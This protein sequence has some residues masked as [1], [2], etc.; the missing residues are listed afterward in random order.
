MFQE[1]ENELS[2]NKINVIKEMKVNGENSSIKAKNMSGNKEKEEN[3][4]NTNSILTNQTNDTEENEKKK[5]NLI[6][7][8]KKDESLN[9]H[10]NKDNIININ[11][12]LNQIIVK[13]NGE[14]QNEI[15]DNN[16]VKEN[17]NKFN[18]TEDYK[19]E[20]ENNNKSQQN[21]KFLKNEEIIYNQNEIEIN[22][23]SSEKEEKALKEKLEEDKK[24]K[25]GEKNKL[26]EKKGKKEEIMKEDPEG[27]NKEKFN[28]NEEKKKTERQT[29]IEKEIEEKIKSEKENPKIFVKE[30]IEEEELD[31]EQLEIEKKNKEINE[32]KKIENKEEIQ[33]EKNQEKEIKK[34]GNKEKENKGEIQE[35]IQENKKK[36]I[37]KEK[38]EQEEIK[39]KENKGK[40][41]EKKEEI[42]EN[43]NKEENKENKINSNINKNMNQI[44]NQQINENEA[45][46]NN[47][48]ILNEINI[49]NENLFKEKEKKNLEEEEDDEDDF[50]DDEELQKLIEQIN[51]K[52]QLFEKQK[53][54]EELKEKMRLEEE[55]RKLEEKKR[56][57]EEEKKKLEAKKKKLEEKRASKKAKMKE[58]LERQEKEILDFIE[59]KKKK[60]EQQKKERELEEKLRKEEEEKKK[61]LEKK[62]KEEEEI[63]EKQ[64]KEKERLDKL[65]E[66]KIERKK[67]QVE[68][69]LEKLNK[70]NQR[71]LEEEKKEK[72]RQEK[73]R[74]EKERIEKE[75]QEKERQEKERHEKELKDKERKRQESLERKRNELRKKQKEKEEK[76]RKLKEEEERKKIEEDKKKEEEKK[77]KKE[78][79][80]AENYPDGISNIKEKDDKTKIKLKFIHMEVEFKTE[81]KKI[82]VYDIYGP[83]KQ[84]YEVLL[85][86]NKY[87]SVFPF[88]KNNQSSN[89]IFGLRDKVENKIIDDN[90]ISGKYLKFNKEEKSWELT[91]LKNKNTEMIFNIYNVPKEINKKDYLKFLNKLNLKLYTFSINCVRESTSSLKYSEILDLIMEIGINSLSKLLIKIII[92]RKIDIYHICHYLE[93]NKNL[94]FKNNFEKLA[95]EII[96]IFKSINIE[97]EEKE[98]NIDKNLEENNCGKRTSLLCLDNNIPINLYPDNYQQD[99]IEK[100]IKNLKESTLEENIEIKRKEISEKL[101]D[102]NKTQK[103]NKAKEII[104]ILTDTTIKKIIKLEF[105]ILSNIPMIIQG[106]TSAGKSFLSSVTSKINKRECLSAAL[107]E[108]TTIEDLLGRDIINNDSSIKFIPGIL[109]LAYKDGKT[110]ILD[111][112][113]LAQPEILSCILGSMTKNELIICNQ[114]FRKME[115]Y[116]VILTMNGEVKGFNEKQ[117][118]ILTSNIVSKFIP[119]SFEE[120]DKEECEEIFKSLLKK[121]ENSKEYLANIKVFIEIHQKMIEEMKI[122]EEMKKNSKSIDPIVTLRNLKYC[123]YLSKNLIHPRLAAE[124]SYT[125]RFPENERKEFENILNKFGACPI[126]N[127]LSEEIENYLQNNFLYYNNTYKKVIY[128]STMALKEGLHPLLVGEKGCGLTTLAKVV[129]SIVSKEYEFLFCS[130]E[131][132]VEDLLGC[133]QPRIKS[134]DKIQDLSSYIKWCDGPVPKAGKRGVPLILDNINY[135]KPQVI[136]CLN[137]ILE[138]NTK[139]NNVEYNILEKE[140]EG[141]IK[142]KK[143]FSILATM[144]IDKDNNKSISKALM[145]RFVPIYVDNDMDINKENLNIIIE[146]IGKKLDSQIK[147][148]N[149]YIENI[150]EKPENIEQELEESFSYSESSDQENEIIIDEEKEGEEEEQKENNN[151]EEEKNEIKSQIPEWYNIK[152]ISEETIIEIQKYFQNN[153]IKKM[154]FKILMKTITKLALVYE[155]IKRF[156]FTMEDCN[157]F[158]ELKFNGKNEIYLNLQNNILSD[159]KEKKNKFFFNEF[160]SDSWKMIMSLIS[161]NISNTC[162]FLQGSPGSGKS[163]AARH[164][165][166]YRIFNNRNPIL[167]VNCNRDLKFDYLVGN[168]NFKDS[169]FNFIDGPLITAIKKG[170][171]ILLDEFNL[172]PESVLTNLLPLFKANINEEIYLKGFPEPIKI[173]PGFLLIA[174]G[175][176][177]KEKGRKII[178]NMIM[179]EILTL[180]ISSINLKSNTTL[181]KNILENEYREIYQEDNSFELDKISSEQIK[182][183]VE[184]LKEDI[185]FNLSLRQIKCLLE[186]ITRF[187]IEENYNVGGFNKIPVIYVIISYIIPQLKIGKKK[188]KEF[189]EKL[190]KTMKY[191]K[192]DELMQFIGSKVELE[193]TIIKINDK[194]EEKRFIKKGNIY[195]VT[196][197]NENIFPQVALQTFFWIRMSCSLKNESPSAE[198]ILLAGTTSYKEYLLN[199]WLSLKVQKDKTIDTLYLTKNTETDNLIG[200]S[201]LDDESKIE[202]QIN[203]LIDNAIFYFY[204]DAK[205]ID[206]KDYNKKF[207]LIKKNKNDSLCLRY[208]YENILKLKSLKKS[209]N[210]N[211]TQIGLKTVTS[212][213]LG[214]IPKAFIF[215]KKLILKG[216]ENP[217]S[218]V[219][220]RLNPLLENPRHLI[221]TEDN[222]KIYND[223]K[224]FKKIY[225]ENIKSVPLN[226]SFRMFFTSREVFH[227]K[228]SKALLSRLT[229][230]NCPNYD[231]ENYLT[232]KLE[233]EINYKIICKSILEETHLVDEIIEFSKI[234][235]TIEKI[236]FLRFIRWC[237]STKNI[238]KRLEKIE[239]QTLLHNQDDSLNYKYIIGISCLRS[240]IDRFESKNRKKIIKEHFKDYLPEKLFNLLTTE[241]NNKLEV[242]PLELIEKNGK[243]YISSIYSGI[244]LEFPENENP[245]IDS[246]K[247]INWTQ[248]SVDIVDAIIV[249]LISNTILILEG[250]PG[251]GKTAISKAVFNYLNIDNE[252]L[253]RINFS[254]SN[255]L[256][257]VFARTIPKIEGEKV[258]TVRKEQGLLSI[259]RKSQNS[260]QFYLQGLIL[261]E[262]NLASDILLEYLYSYMN[263]IL[264]H[265]DYISPDGIKYQNIGN[266]GV[267]ATMNGAKLSN[268]RTNLSN[269]FM[270]RCHLLKLSDYSINE[271]ELLAE[272]ILTNLP[273]KEAFFKVIEY[274]KISSRIASKYSDFEGNTFREILKLRQFIDKCPDIPID[275][276]LELILS[277]NI[278]PS[279]MENF[280]AETGFNIISNSLNDLKLKIENKCL[281]FDNFVKYKL[282]NPKNYEIKTQFTISQ[283]EALMKIMIGLLAERPILLTGDIGTGKTFIV[284]QLANLIGANL[285]VIQFNSETTSLDILGRLELTIDKNKINNLK[286][287]I[288]KFIEDLIKIKYKKITEIIIENELLNISKIQ[289][290]LENEKEDF[291]NYDLD[292]QNEYEEIRTQLINLSGIKK[293][294]FNFNLSALIKAMIQGDWILLDDINFAPHEI[295][296]L[297]PLLEEEPTLKIYE[298][299]PVLFF[300]K[301][302]SKIINKE[303]DFEIHPNFKLIM[304]T[305]KDHN[306]SAA[307]KSRCLCVQIKPFKEPKDY[308]ELIANN[309]IYCDIADNNIIDI[310][311]KIGY[312]FYKL[313]E[314][315]E[316]TNYI[317]K[318]YILSSVNLV[319]L[320]KLIICNQP[321]NDKKLAH[322]IEYC[323][324]SAFK[325]MNKKKE[326]IEFFRKE[327][328]KDINIEITPIRNIKRSHEYYLKKCEINIFSYYFIK[329]KEIEN[330]LEKMNEKINKRFIDYRSE[331]K[332]NIIN[333]NINEKEIIKDIPREQL[334]SKLESFT[335]PEIKEYIND[336]DELII[337]INDFLEEDDKLYQKLYFLNYLRM[338]LSNLSE[339]NEEKLFGIKINKM[340]CNK[341]FFLKYNIKEDVSITY[342]RI[343]I[344]FKNMIKYFDDIIP[345]K[346]STNEL[347]F[348]ILSIYYKSFKK[349]YKEIKENQLFEYFIFFMLS[350]IHLRRIVKKYSV[351][352]KNSVG[353]DLFNILKNYNDEI[354]VNIHERKIDIEKY[355]LS[356][357]L[358]RNIN[359]KEKEEIEEILGIK[360]K[361]EYKNYISKDIIKSNIIYYYPKKFYEEKHLLKIFFFYNI[362]IKKYIDDNELKKIIPDE[363]YDYN[364]VIDFLFKENKYYDNVDER[365]IW[366]NKYNFINII[367]IG[368]KLLEA[369]RKV[370][371]ESIKLNNGID[372]FKNKNIEINEEN[373]N[374]VI[375]KIDIIKK[376][377][378][379]DKLWSSIQKK[380]E[381][382]EEKKKQLIFAKEKNVLKRKLDILKAKYKNILMEENYLFLKED[383]EEIMNKIKENNSKNDIEKDLKILENKFIL[384]KESQEKE[385]NQRE[386]YPK[387]NLNKKITIYSKILYTYS[388]LCSIIEEFNN[389][390]ITADFIR[391][392][393]K[394]QKLIK[395]SQTNIDV[396]SAYKEQIFSSCENDSFVSQEMIEIFKHMAKSYLISEIIK[397]SLENKFD[398]YIIH[399]MQI[400]EKIL[401]DIAVIFTEDEYIYLPKLNSKDII[402]CFRYGEDNYKPGILNP[403]KKI[404]LFFDENENLSRNEILN[405]IRENFTKIIKRKEDL[406][407]INEYLEKIDTFYNNI[408][409]IQYNIDIS[410]L[411]KPLENLKDEAINY[412]NRII[413][414]NKYKNSNNFDGK[415]FDGEKI[416]VK[417]IYALYEGNKKIPTLFNILNDVISNIQNSNKN[418]HYGYRIMEFYGFDLFSDNQSKTMAIIIFSI[419]SI[420]NKEFKDYINEDMISILQSV[421]QE[422]IELVISIE[423]PKFED[424]QA[425]NIFKILFYSFLKKFKTKYGELKSIF[426]ENKNKFLDIVNKIKTQVINKIN[427]EISEYNTKYSIYEENKKKLE[428]DIEDKRH[429]FYKEKS[430]ILNGIKY[431]FVN[432]DK[433]FEKTDEYKN[434]SKKI[435]FNES[436]KP[437]IDHNWE[438]NKENFEKL[439]KKLISIKNKENLYSIQN[440]INNNRIDGTNKYI[441]K[442]NFKYY[443]G[444]LNKLNQNIDNLK[445]INKYDYFLKKEIPVDIKIYEIQKL[446]L[447]MINKIILQL[448]NYQY[449]YSLFEIKKIHIGNYAYKNN[450]ISNN[451]NT[452]QNSNFIFIKGNNNPVFLNK[453]MKINLGLYIIGCDLKNIGS[454]S[455]QNN[456]PNSLKYSIKQDPNNSIIIFIDSK[457][458]LNPYQDLK[459]NFKLNIKDIIPGFYSSECE[460]I[461]SDENKEFDKCM[462]NVFINVIP[463]IIKFSIPNIE[464]SLIN[465]NISISNYIEDLRI[466]H[467]FP[468][469]YFPESLGIELINRNYN[470]LKVIKDNMKNKGQLIVKSNFD[471][472]KKEINFELSLFLKSFPLLKFQINY[473]NPVLFGIRIFDAKNFNLQSIKIMKDMEK[474]FYLFN[475]SNKNIK[476]NLSYNQNLIKITSSKKELIPKEFVK[477]RVKNI[478]L[479]NVTILNI[480]DKSIKI[481]SIKYPKITFYK[482]MIACNFD[483]FEEVDKNILEGFKLYSINNNF[484]V[485]KE[486][487]HSKD[488]YL[489][490]IFSGYLIFKKEIITK[491]IGKYNFEN[492]GRRKVYGYSNE[493]SNITLFKCNDKKLK[494][495]LSFKIGKDNYYCSIFS[496]NKR[497]QFLKNL[498]NN[499]A[500][501]ISNNLQELNLG[502]SNI[503]SQQ[504]NIS[505]ENSV[506]NLNI[507]NEVVSVENIIIFLLKYSLKFK[508]IDNFKKYLQESFDKLYPKAYRDIKQFFIP[509]IENENVKIILDK[510][511]YILSFT[512]LL[513]SPGELLEYEYLE[514]EPLYIKKEIKIEDNQNLNKLQKE[515]DY[516]FSNIEK[517]ILLNKDLIYYNRKIMVHEENDVFSKYEKQIKENDIKV[518]ENIEEESTEFINSCHEKIIQL[519]EYINKNNINISNLLPFLDDSKK[520]LMKIPFILSKKGKEEQLNTSING[521]QMIYYYLDKLKETDIMKTQ[522]EKIILEYLNEFKYFLSKFNIFSVKDQNLSKN[523]NLEY[524][525]LCELPSDTKYDEVKFYNDNDEKNTKK[526]DFNENKYLMGRIQMEQYNSEILIKDKYENKK[527][528]SF[529]KKEDKVKTLNIINEISE[530]ERKNLSIEGVLDE[531]KMNNDE[532]GENKQKKALKKD[533]TDFKEELFE[534]RDIRKLFGDLKNISATKFLKDIMKIVSTEN[535]KYSII[536][537]IEKIENIKKDKFENLNNFYDSKFD[538]SYSNSSSVLQNIISNL[539]RKKV[540][541]FNEKEILPKTLN[542]TYLEILLDISAT[543]S[544]DQR[545][546]SLLV[547]TGLSLSFSKYGVKIRIGVFA[548]RDNVWVLSDDFSYENL[549]LQL[550]RLRDALSLRKRILSF[551]ADALKKL[552][553]SFYEQYNKKY[554]QILISN[555]ISSQIVDKNLNW[556]ELGQRIIVFGLKSNFEEAFKNEN[557]DIYE[558]ILKVPTSD[559]AQIVQEFFEPYEIISQSEK[560]IDSYSNL[561]NAIIDS[562]LDNNEELNENNVRP[563]LINDTHYPKRKKNDIEILKIFIDNNLKEQ[564]YFAQ[565]IPFL[566]LK[567]SK[568]STKKINKNLKIPSLSE[569]EKLSSKDNYNKNYSMEEIISFIV[570]LL[571]PLFRQI[572]PSN[573]ASGKIPSTSGGSL[574]IQGIKKW[575]CSGF[576]YTYIF[577]KQGGKNKKK[578]NLSYVIDLSRS[579]LLLCNY[580][581]CIVTIVLLLIAP[582]TVEDNE[583]IFIDVL[584]NT[585]YGVKIVDFNSKCTIFQNISKI[586][587]IINIINEE[588]NYSCCPGSC[589]Y[590]SYQLLSERREEKKIFLIT[591]GFVTD[592]NEI[593]LVLN[594]IENCEN[595]GIDLVTIG[596][597]TF[598]Y[599]I[600]DVYPN[601][602]YSP[603]IRNIQDALFSCFFYSKETSIN[604]FDSNLILAEF[605]EKI[606]KELT[607]I[608][609]EKPKDKKLEDSISNDP[610]QFNLI[611]NENSNLN[612]IGMDGITKKVLNP[613]DEPYFDVFSDFKI[614]IV[615]LYLGDDKHDKNITTEV[616]EQNAG[617]SLK[618]KGFKY[619]LVYSYG[620]AINKLSVVENNNCPYSELWIFCSKGDGSLPVKA[621]DKDNNKITIFLEMV[622]DFNK[623]G[624]ALFLFCDN[625]PFVLEANL[626]LKE[627][628]KFEEG[629]INFEMKGNYN[630]EVEQNRFIYEKDSE[631]INGN[632]FFQPD[633]FLK[634][635]GKA[636]ERFSLRIGLNKFSEGIT[637]SF[638]ETSNNSEDYSPFTP[639]AYLTDP[640]N[641]RPFI[642]YY[643]PKVETGRG[644]IVVHGGF[645]S[646]FY[647]FQQDGTGRLVI[648]IACW[649]I[650]KEEININIANGIEKVIPSIPIPQN[651]NIAFDK[652]IKIKGVGKMFS[653]LILDVSGSMRKFYSSLFGLANQIIKN[654]MKNDENEGIIILFGTYAKAIVNGKYRLLDLIDINKAN[655]G[656]GT[657]F[658]IAF[659]EAEKYI[660]NRNNFPKKRILFLTDGISSSSQL[661]PICNKMTQENFQINIVGFNNNP[662]NYNSSSTTFEHLRKFASPNCFFTS[663]NFKEIEEICINIFAAE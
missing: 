362:F 226:E 348:S 573:I 337:I 532:D 461:L 115:G 612:S 451:I 316:Q 76:E 541:I 445:I 526:N 440:I 65:E 262:I 602:C 261:D 312:G 153:N 157:D 560:I 28:L 64:R 91:I 12:N 335:L 343:L 572:M 636:N 95:P 284:E 108:N 332:E 321:I 351:L 563:I 353:Y 142:M 118:N 559:Q 495:A 431:T 508:I 145:N 4:E 475:M 66:E 110:L 161:S 80:H 439:A 562:L 386:N 621:V 570:T 483:C 299:D 63:K 14:N 430:G 119:I 498:Q 326:F 90:D 308:S 434:W 617:K 124:I 35:K 132:S 230:I 70:E 564:K 538:I 515:Y 242:C 59:N 196:N 141:P 258:S 631:K 529:K 629:K 456:Y 589:V 616:F 114:T 582:S 267:I 205:N 301:D 276:L 546:A 632:G 550:S 489:Y 648:S 363:L 418:Y 493:N 104:C 191:N 533:L 290:F 497:N 201:S 296:G 310:A 183:I 16:N 173:T 207:K 513:L 544:E 218:S 397:N 231:N 514:E 61:I 333:K 158:I 561:V 237:Q 535:Q 586:Q 605:D 147:E 234:I 311:K 470:N 597:G 73:E 25:E 220:E 442:N 282:I 387:D 402:Y 18:I 369:I 396:L 254:P 270:N 92:D 385:E 251:R 264:H 67:K 200:I 646:A 136:E 277:R 507:S 149:N 516:Y 449:Y 389:I 437:H 300:T 534:I 21:A 524:I 522:F 195:L 444:F 410:W 614:L 20:K 42:Q 425:V 68:D 478:N 479:E 165:G 482:P 215:G 490:N 263:S 239:F 323:F 547:C 287:S 275:Y 436:E 44:I 488:R 302:R 394:F 531:S 517:N 48:K 163:C 96:Y 340:E 167:S 350:K 315:E 558:N 658:Y 2:L 318:N 628:I 651:N 520:I 638:A 579:S 13:E 178:S 11:N 652:W 294:H 180:E 235:E 542:N 528:L 32:R 411:I 60:E 417:A 377:L 501:I 71:L 232:L 125:A 280:K 408:D 447:G 58:E 567:L 313:K 455:I 650:R 193:P 426:E 197:M 105:G 438:I 186:R 330:I 370:E 580:S 328:Q 77:L 174:T 268:S 309:L 510:F 159:S 622:A 57:E 596:V 390:K 412:P 194:E 448:D 286:K 424:T 213:N 553:N 6:H 388:K 423:Y 643:D 137:P 221:I 625:Y 381:I 240:I 295:E 406:E 228:L 583:E 480:N 331:L 98:D 574:S 285:K 366:K 272:K 87:Y 100:T 443:S 233:P 15:L 139:Y 452:K 305:S 1:K 39:E 22:K 585:V 578:Y 511:S 379:D 54:E 594:L 307:I 657:N 446:N 151:Q 339:I 523:I 509:K 383:I 429:K 210:E 537:D 298:N 206:E 433:D 140:N 150:Q 548:E 592:K 38:E 154:N 111:E 382:L 435:K 504:V 393:I 203:Y 36:E 399:F 419:N 209:F 422:L 8:E 356:I 47:S 26:E 156:G 467:S 283:K 349:Q 571:T 615:I 199:E 635:P 505:E 357:P 407:K 623:K 260:M 256:E 391:K 536:K 575:I 601:C 345:D 432:I 556:N 265:E 30:N 255:I 162:I 241:F 372:I 609:N 244:V 499:R 392:V 184:D 663:N 360:D 107:S 336:I 627:Y 229:I 604:S 642:L 55:Q 222:Q 288:K 587:E 427:S 40:E 252:N 660:Y 253:K 187:C 121:E 502:I 249:A 243:K 102:Y 292:I 552:K 50:E 281:C 551:P 606:K 214:I 81:P 639:F 112:C 464:Y 248:S 416:M 368:Y 266:I 34:K 325:N 462:I 581:H 133:Y 358:I 182:Q 278:P 450:Y 123:C 7:K 494:I 500:K 122:K 134:K 304:T 185:Q 247:D 99:L 89:I 51:A 485:S 460:L 645:T 160:N 469:D 401:N 599:G 347:E 324:F 590:A 306:I 375:E 400:D 82:E 97:R 527:D 192:F 279:E 45:K 219:I 225:N 127:N 46:I 577:E 152:N 148:I 23:E 519:T 128:L 257:D 113:D 83:S 29:K 608:L 365:V 352:K 661:Q 474:D 236:E 458:E 259:L 539:I 512:L 138:D 146:N 198:N 598:P 293:T 190:D 378:N 492:L 620:D 600:K 644:P 653:I 395:K 441:E 3:L 168:Y 109:L 403:T 303:T 346:I 19:D 322:I 555:L 466:F 484:K 457:K 246:L 459:I 659:Q 31:N 473:K 101:S 208:I 557:P 93:H 202:N 274:F 37:I 169:K 647:D 27:Q 319:Y 453:N 476:L 454:L 327:L 414:K 593:Q 525:T 189:L 655:V 613:E 117:R 656:G 380:Y 24:M 297:M 62:I 217:E 496:N 188:I 359:L 320:S 591:D 216:I 17:D 361:E 43:E 633:H 85:E 223:D 135:S 481:E 618:K 421:Y 317:L 78:K 640:N 420:I 250:P 487:I 654:Q 554:C 619:D 374:I 415:I 204:L 86:N 166:A 373:I 5:N 384:I 103:A 175:N 88:Y 176:S 472:Y 129:A 634:V 120:M 72:I 212:F 74:Q 354:K 211:N 170:E 84:G 569:L 9:S 164:F 413:I 56:K 376:Y 503:I 518:D 227:V 637:L 630:N 568:F 468:G 130:S 595:E 116:N 624:G 33:G 334:L 398:Q 603:S 177:S 143:G 549:Q 405:K 530:E 662:R 94:K 338:I 565:N 367:N 465:N 463:L 404:D 53:K 344:W 364:L 75:R 271:K 52:K 289:N 79:E 355:N 477:L 144:R 491:N 238:Y 245:N 49:P 626:L 314:K 486:T 41:K 291:Y 641:K 126:D 273:N 69:E 521:V 428:K 341:E 342:A 409:K 269:S 179:D 106:F 649:L 181:I 155:R 576:T 171:C 131:T 224:I 543:M 172:C 545:I 610:G 540:L 329:N 371:K 10:Q 588:I 506:I 607:D 471:N 566:N 584:I 611:Q